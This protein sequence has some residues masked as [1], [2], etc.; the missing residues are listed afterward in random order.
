M[1]TREK[2]AFKRCDYKNEILPNKMVVT[3][4]KAATSADPHPKKKKKVFK[5]NPVGK[6]HPGRP[7]KR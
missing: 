1:K 2:N 3:C 4:H 6:S 7:Q 5:Y